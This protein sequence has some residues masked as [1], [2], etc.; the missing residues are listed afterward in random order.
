MIS[1]QEETTASFLNSSSYNFS[2]GLGADLPFGDMADR[3]GTNLGVKFQVERQ[4]G[5]DWVFGLQY[6]FLFG[7]TVNEDVLE[8][9]RLDNGNVLG[10]NSTYAVALQRMRG[11]FLGLHLGKIFRLSENYKSGVKVSVAAGVFQHHIRLID[12]E[13]SF[14][15][16]DP[17]NSK[18]YDKLSRGLGLKEFIGWQYL[19]QDRRMNF[20]IGLEFTQG[21][22]Q[23]IR[24]YNFTTG[25]LSDK[26]SRFDGTVGIRVG[27]ILPFYSG[28]EDEEIFY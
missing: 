19:A 27:W 2:L 11:G 4:T 12:D 24:D 23:N 8:G 21:F 18:G 7:S 22:T 17:G 20:Y 6:D 1:A 10:V 13:R 14:P 25:A 16:F 26:S 3:F 9:I 15:Q 5:S 28:Y